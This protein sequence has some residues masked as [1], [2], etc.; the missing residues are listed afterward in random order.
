MGVFSS[1]V[2]SSEIQ[3]LIKTGTLNFAYAKSN[4][5]R[6]PE[7]DNSKQLKDRLLNG[8]AYRKAVIFVDNSGAD[9]VFGVLPFARYLLKRGTDVILAANTWPSVN[10]ITVVQF[11]YRP[12]RYHY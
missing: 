3:Q 2:R 10:D 11:N 7:I 12:L 8:A 1:N 4:V 9:F 5:G 6:P